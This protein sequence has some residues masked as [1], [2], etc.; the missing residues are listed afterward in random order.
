MAHKLTLDAINH[1]SLGQLIL[2]P[3]SQRIKRLFLFFE[4]IVGSE[5]SIDNSRRI[6]VL[7]QTFA[8]AALLFQFFSGI[9]RN[10]K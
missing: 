10:P 8:P 3:V 7:S 4:S 9:E 5:V 2:E 6:H 1:I